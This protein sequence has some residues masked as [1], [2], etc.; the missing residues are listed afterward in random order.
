MASLSTDG[1]G[2]LFNETER[3]AWDSQASWAIDPVLG[4]DTNAGTPAAPLATMAEFSNR[5]SG[6]LYK[7]AGTL[8]LVG[9]VIDSSLSLSGTRF[10]PGA[11]L[12]VSGT[13]TQLG[14]GTV[15][16]TAAIG[17]GWQVTTTGIDW[18]LIPLGSL[19]QFSTGQSAAIAEVVDAN[20]VIIGMIAAPGTSVTSVAPTNGSTVTASSRSRMWPFQVN[21]FQ[22]GPLTA[23]PLLIQNVSFDAA[24]ASAGFIMQGGLGIQLFACE[25]NNHNTIRVN[26]PL[27]V[28]ACKFTIT[29][30][31]FWQTG[32]A[33]PITVACVVG[34]TGATIFSSTS[35]LVN[36]HQVLLTG[37]R[38]GANNASILLTGINHIRNT[39]GPVIV[40]GNGWISASGSLSGS[41]GNTGIGIDVTFGKLSYVGGGNKPTVTGASDCRV[42]GTARTY[43]QIP[44]TA[45]D[46]TTPTNLVGNGSCIVQE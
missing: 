11:S 13:T 40:S 17:G 5:F 36:H 46:A 22:Q 27:N 42:G 8:Q 26:N 1:F 23:T 37:A 16:S 3:S 20:N 21:A 14:S 32:A 28:R 45:L 2:S 19:V 31:M 30:S 29:A 12:T 9:N 39:A 34:G 24:S 4:S 18:T 15:S 43:A 25:I 10:G 33:F 6:L 7:V 38:L 44:Y 35:G 41:V